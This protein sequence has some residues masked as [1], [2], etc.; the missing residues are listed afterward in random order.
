MSI[1]EEIPFSQLVQRPKDTMALLDGSPRRRI[2]LDR[3]DGE[4]LILESAAH[5]EDE[6]R[7]L[8]TAG[9]LLLSLIRE[10]SGRRALLAVLPQAFP[11]VRFLPD[12][13]TSRFC[14]TLLATRLTCC[15]RVRSI[16][17]VSVGLSLRCST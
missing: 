7:V 16:C 2:R 8:A 12:N 6:D 14:A 11:W 1:T 10:E 9:G 4:D 13:D 5:A 15:N 17:M 3:R